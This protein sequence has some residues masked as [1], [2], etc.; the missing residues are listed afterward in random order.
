M[1]HGY[2]D[3]Q[4]AIADLRIFQAYYFLC[5]SIVHGKMWMSEIMPSPLLLFTISLFLY[6]LF[7]IQYKYTPQYKEA[8]RF[9]YE[10]DCEF[11][12]LRS[13]TSHSHSHILRLTNRMIPVRPQLLFFYKV[14]SLQG[15]ARV[16]FL[17]TEAE[18]RGKIPWCPRATRQVS[19]IFRVIFKTAQFYGN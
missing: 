13:T 14:C 18:W 17:L 4:F 10:Y 1:A 16:Y 15:S 2:R 7:S 19:K 12:N 3:P 11:T 5:R 8:I 9:Y 6:L